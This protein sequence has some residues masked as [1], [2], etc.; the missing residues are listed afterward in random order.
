V[1]PISKITH[2]ITHP[3]QTATAVADQAFGVAASGVRTTMRLID[4][5]AGQVRPTT[6]APPPPRAPEHAPAKQATTRKTAAKRAPSARAATAGPALLQPE[7]AE[8]DDLRTPS[9]IPAADEA[10]NP[11]TI[12]TDLHQPGTEPLMDPATVKAARSE[13]EVK[14][15]AAEV[16]K[17]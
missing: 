14:Q 13:A 10:Y 8:D 4:R 6:E 7:T 17:N 16:D 12:E 2:A 1:N 9:G 11:D 5:A 3:V 15:R